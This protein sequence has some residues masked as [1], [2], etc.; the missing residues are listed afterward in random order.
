MIERETEARSQRKLQNDAARSLGLVDESDGGGFFFAGA[1]A[2]ATA[3]LGA[4]TEC[5]CAAH[6]A[7]SS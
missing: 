7:R 2:A 3:G 6:S 4:N 5:V 1:R